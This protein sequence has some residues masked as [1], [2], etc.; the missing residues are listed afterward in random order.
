MK[1]EYQRAKD[2]IV[3]ALQRDSAAATANEKEQAAVRQKLEA[4]KREMETAL[5]AG[6]REKY[7]AAG[8]IA[9]KARLDLEFFEKVKAANAAK[10]G[11][12]AERDTQIRAALLNEE[13]RVRREFLDR[14]KSSLTDAVKA[15]RDA[16]NSIIELEESRKSWDKVM[17][18]NSNPFTQ[19]ETWIAIGQFHNAIQ[20]QLDRLKIVTGGFGSWNTTNISRE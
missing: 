2:E 4:A 16:Q 1:S 8:M 3:Q 13:W 9:E 17:K 7:T 10:P 11:A 12:T 15:C 19:R 20:G 5:A 6:D 18:N 14:M